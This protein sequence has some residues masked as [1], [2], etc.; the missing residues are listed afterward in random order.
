[1]LVLITGRQLS[2]VAVEYELGLVA[3]ECTTIV[4]HWYARAAVK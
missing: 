2:Y 1:M 3:T 4:F